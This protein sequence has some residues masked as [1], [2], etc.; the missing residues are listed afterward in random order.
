MG[1]FSVRVLVAGWF[2]FAGMGTTAGDLLARD[3]AV[4]WL[5]QADIPYDISAVAPFGEGVDWRTS[6]PTA[7]THI[8]FVCGPFGNGPPVAEFLDKFRECRL[9]GLNLSMLQRLEDWNPF[10]VL[11][12]RDS[13][14]T[15][16][17]DISLLHRSTSRRVAGLILVHPQHEYGMRGGHAQANRALSELLSAQN[18]VA[19][20]IDTCL[21]TSSTGLSQ[22]AQVEALITRMDFVA[23]TRVHGLTLALKNGIPALAVDPIK[24]KAKVHRQAMALGWPAAIGVDELSEGRLADLCAY[25]L[26]AEARAKA[27]ECRIRAIRRLAGLQNEFLSAITRSSA[28]A[29]I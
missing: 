3:V 23:T 20:P 8:V 22:P 9:F 28:P 12:E 26:T 19:I 27:W 24:G 21:E 18:I 16:R 11:F 25:C 10:E 6:D 5:S 17:P 4:S 2:S 13:T 7:Y 1:L 15:M 29:D 14:R